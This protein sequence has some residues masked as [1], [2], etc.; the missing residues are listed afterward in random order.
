MERVAAPWGIYSP[1]A[2]VR[3]GLEGRQGSSASVPMTTRRTFSRARGKERRRGV[4][5]VVVWVP[6]CVRWRPR[7]EG[8]RGGGS[9]VGRS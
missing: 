8:V 1:R 9:K 7:Y 5:S 3:R 4:A 2:R 6:G